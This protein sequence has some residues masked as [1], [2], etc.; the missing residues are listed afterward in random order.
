MLESDDNHL[1]R[2]HANSDSLRA[3]ITYITFQNIGRDKSLADDLNMGQGI[4][5][6]GA[7]LP[8]DPL[9]FSPCPEDLLRHATSLPHPPHP[10]P[11]RIQPPPYSPHPPFHFHYRPLASLPRPPR[12]PPH[13]VRP[14]SASDRPTSG[15]LHPP[16]VSALAPRM[17]ALYLS[18]M[19]ICV[20][21]THAR[22]HVMSCHIINTH[23]I[24]PSTYISIHHLYTSLYIS[25]PTHRTHDLLLPAASSRIAPTLTSG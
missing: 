11:H 24:P 15:C 9:R 10:P 22:H 20:S 7:C 14:A 12:T 18:I 4:V 5:S 16:S 19:H 8:C 6:R 2:C 1:R 17:L 3:Y 25:T 13:H 23:T 21:C